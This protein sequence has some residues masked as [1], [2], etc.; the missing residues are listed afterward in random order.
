LQVV[1]R[2]ESIREP[3][4]AKRALPGAGLRRNAACADETV[5]LERKRTTRDVKARADDQAER[6][7]AALAR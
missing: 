2:T 3:I 4:I 1:V 5:F 7:A 6:Q